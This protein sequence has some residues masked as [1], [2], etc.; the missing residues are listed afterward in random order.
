MVMEPLPSIASSAFFKRFSMTQSNS[1]AEIFAFILLISYSS[2]SLP[3]MDEMLV[4]LRKYKENV[5]V[6]PI[7]YKYSFGNQATKVGDNRNTVQ[8]Y[9]FVAY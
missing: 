1:G 3:N 4:M 5:D 9:L 8:E 6:I 7:D 2:N